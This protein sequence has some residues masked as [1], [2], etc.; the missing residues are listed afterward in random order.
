MW[1]RLIRIRNIGLLYLLSVTTRKP[2]STAAAV[3]RIRM[4]LGLMDPDPVVRGTDPDPSIIKPK[5]NLNS[6][7]YA[8]SL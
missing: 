1:I 5:K 2:T 8:T 7:C 6:Y 4:R 3:L